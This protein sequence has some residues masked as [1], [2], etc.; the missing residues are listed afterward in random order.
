[1]VKDPLY[2]DRPIDD[3]IQSFLY[4]NRN[5]VHCETKKTPFEMMFVRKAQLRWQKLIPSKQQTNEI[6][7]NV[8][9]FNVNDQVYMKNFNNDKWQLAY[10]FKILGV[11]S[12][13][14]KSNDKI[15]KRHANHLSKC[16]NSSNEANNEFA[17]E[18]NIINEPI[19]QK[20]LRQVLME[21]IACLNRGNDAVEQ[22]REE[23]GNL[24]VADSVDIDINTELDVQINDSIEP[25]VPV[26]VDAQHTEGRPK[27]A[28]KKPNKLDL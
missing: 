4:M 17:P 8:C 10:I 15:Y 6:K 12:Y 14:V 11:N 9:K 24:S 22:S 2:R 28:K 26:V 23:E 25:I 3:V 27:R 5:A 19:N 18:S 21:P 20:N 7:S 13:L 16:I 1:M